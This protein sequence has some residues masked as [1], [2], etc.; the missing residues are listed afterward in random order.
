LD[1]QNSKRFQPKKLSSF[2]PKK[3]FKSLHS[4]SKDRHSE[5]A[6]SS[7]SQPCLLDL[8]KYRQHLL[9]AEKNK[10]TNKN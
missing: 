6:F 9:G 10:E 8:E 5:D 3:P 1:H 2:F 4:P 7:K